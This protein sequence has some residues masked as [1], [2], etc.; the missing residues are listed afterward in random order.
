MTADTVIAYI[1]HDERPQYH[2]RQA[3]TEL[4]DVAACVYQSGE[5]G[6]SLE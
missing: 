1:T 5:S 6:A 4:S 2:Q 3:G